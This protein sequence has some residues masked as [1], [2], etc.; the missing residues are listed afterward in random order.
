MLE[1]DDENLKEIEDI[2]YGWDNEEESEELK[3][4][5]KDVIHNVKNDIQEDAEKS[6]KRK[7]FFITIILILIIFWFAYATIT[8]EVFLNNSINIMDL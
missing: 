2:K 6:G 4:I 7:I 1:K 3:K 8:G 5:N